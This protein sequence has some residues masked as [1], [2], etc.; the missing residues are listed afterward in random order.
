MCG[1]THVQFDNYRDPITKVDY[2]GKV[3]PFVPD[4]T[5]TVAL[6]YKHPEGYF[7]R[8]EWLWTG[9]TYFDENN[10]DTTSQSAYSTANARIGYAKNN[11]SVYAFVNNLTDT[12]YYS[13][14]V[15]NTRGTPGDP[16][17]IGVRLGVSF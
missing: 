6:Q 11:Y 3:A 9:R 14:K 12:H 1:Y 17:M 5:S 7:A 16:R 10:T 8:A 4:Y 13:F 15:D 2:A